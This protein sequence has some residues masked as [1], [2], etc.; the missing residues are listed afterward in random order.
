MKLKCVIIIILSCLLLACK[1][2]S[3]ISAQVEGKF[4]FIKAPHAG[5]VTYVTPGSTIHAGELLFAVSNDA[6][7]Y[8]YMHL[9]NMIRSLQ[10]DDRKNVLLM[11]QPYENLTPFYRKLIAID[12]L[13]FLNLINKERLSSIRVNAQHTAEVYNVRYRPGMYVEKNV[14]IL[15]T[16]PSGHVF[17]VFYV[18]K[19]LQ[20]Q[21]RLNVL[22]H[23]KVNKKLIPA[24]VTYIAFKPSRSP[25][26]ATVSLS[27]KSQAP[28][29]Y[30]IH[31]KPLSPNHLLMPGNT[32][33]VV[34]DS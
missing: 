32:I 26:L 21:L 24:Q 9:L 10:Y 7:S 1:H 13:R 6:A 16:L 5:I 28:A 4:E 29:L 19:K 34:I 8:S 20:K 18:D 15:S 27:G 11:A 2:E 31:A 22:V 33:S 3:T 14:P 25:Q 17:V 30:Q 23:L 12:Q